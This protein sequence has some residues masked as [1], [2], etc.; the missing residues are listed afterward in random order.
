M[1]FFLFLLIG[2][3]MA[4]CSYTL[5]VKDG[6]F[7][8][9]RKQ[10]AVA[11]P[12][13]QKEIKKTKSRVEKGELAYLLAQS[14]EATN[15]S[16]LAI[17]WYM[18]A[19]S[20]GY[21]VD[22]LRDYAYALKKAER[23]DEAILAF[24]DL[25][26]EIGSPYEYKREINACEI[27]QGWLEIEQPEYQVDLLP[28]NSGQADYAP[29]IYEDGRLVFA[30]DRKGSQGKDVYAWTGNAFSDLYIADPE[31]GDTEDFDPAINTPGNEG[32]VAFN[33]DY[34]EMYFTRCG[35]QDEKVDAYCRL[36]FSRRV[37]N[38][39]STPVELDFMEAEVNYMHPA[40]SQDEQRL[41]FSS[42]HPDGWGGYDLYYVKRQGEGWSFPVPLSRSVNSP[43]DEQFPYLKDD[44]LY[45]A[46]NYHPGLGGLDIFRTY[47]RTE[48]RWTS[49]F[50]LKPPLNSGGDDFG[51]V[52]DPNYQR[53]GKVIEVGYFSSSRNTGIGEDDI[54]RF[55]RYPPPPPPPVEKDPAPIEY[56]MVLD[57]YVLE[58]IYESLGDPNS[59]VLG[60]KPL[61]GATVEYQLN[62]KVQK[63]TVGEDGL[64]RIELDEDSDY[65]FTA[66]KQGFLA[67]Q[68]DFTSRGI[69]KD[70]RYPQQQFE[71][72]IVLDKIFLD[73]EIVLEN[74]YYDFDEFFIREDAKPTLD[75]LAQNLQL[76]P[77]ISIELASHTDCRGNDRYN[78]NLSQQ[79][80][81]SAVDYL[82]EQ[83][84]N[85]SRLSA[86][87]YGESVPAN[88][89][90]CSRCT[91]E[92]HQENRRTTFKIIE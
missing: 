90:V 89:C 39:W 80:A 56:S 19:Y 52:I 34:S 40:L 33:Q 47:E 70:P 17:D 25:G 23:Y 59:R 77:D 36:F 14:Y 55:E 61:A 81:Q 87:G 78:T 21:G 66:R 13:F 32:T 41:Y 75:E 28:F 86:R 8:H 88:D 91:E 79:R 6:R 38:A 43:G 57:V 82:I 2:S 48:G 92:E 37:G 9:D 71:L 54:F 1:R 72:E 60:R 53:Q 5:K 68:A 3:L 18:T 62:G 73:R 42:N 69:A 11:I 20:N 10:Y 7:A 45:F 12:L 49:P 64:L 44:T 51:I 76:N 74:I 35:N 83:G 46:S 85:P 31:G 27:A 29:S 58:K 26:F 24:K 15:Q 84:I 22:A 63:D 16:E 30:S 67:N 65:Q 4:G 50:N